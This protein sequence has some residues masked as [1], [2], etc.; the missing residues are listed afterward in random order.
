MT[1]WEHLVI[2]HRLPDRATERQS[3][4]DARKLQQALDRVGDEGWQLVEMVP[5]PL[6]A[7]EDGVL[8]F[9]VLR[10]PVPEG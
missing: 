2:T 9:L 1:R 7:N 8:Y 6:L 3:Q 5:G 10:R 4:R